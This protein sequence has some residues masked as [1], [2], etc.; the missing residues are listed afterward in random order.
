MASMRRPQGSRGGKSTQEEGQ[1]DGSARCSGE[2]DLALD[3]IRRE[4]IG[5]RQ[6]YGE[7][8]PVRK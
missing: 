6:V 5:Q 4:R 7:N 8:P 2:D 1:R 3:A